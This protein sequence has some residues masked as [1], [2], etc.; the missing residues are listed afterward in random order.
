MKCIVLIARVFHHYLAQHA[1]ER[2]VNRSN[3]IHLL[4]IKLQTFIKDIAIVNLN[5]GINHRLLDKYNNEILENYIVKMVASEVATQF[6][7]HLQLRH[8]NQRQETA[9]S[10]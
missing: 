3:E 5:I 4:L 6:E 8:S 9:L 7:H 10:T 1:I 2:Q